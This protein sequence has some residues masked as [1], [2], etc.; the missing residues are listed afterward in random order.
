[1]SINLPCGLAWNTAVM[2]E[3][4]LLVLLLLGY[5]LNKLEEQVCELLVLAFFCGYYFSR[6][7]SELNKV[8]YLILL[9]LM[10]G[11]LV[12]VIGCMIFLSS[13]DVKRMSMVTVLFLA[14]LS[15]GILC[16]HNSFP[17]T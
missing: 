12:I 2:H 13:P 11:S 5:V 10:R 8:V 9:I 4:V 14:Q 7:S 3:L 16:L 17:L 1:M 15:C 6:H